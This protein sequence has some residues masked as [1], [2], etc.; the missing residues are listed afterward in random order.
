MLGHPALQIGMR[1]NWFGLA[2]ERSTALLGRISGS[3]VLSGI[4][5]SSTDHHCAPYSLT[6]E[7]VAVYRMHPLIPD[8]CDF[9]G[10]GRR[11]LLEQREF[12]ELAGPAHPRLMDSLD[13]GRPALL[14]RHA[15][16]PARSACTTIPT[17]P[18]ATPT[19]STAGDRPGGPRHPAR[20]GARVPR[21]NDFRELLRMPRP[22]S[23]DDLTDNTRPGRGDRRGLQRRRRDVDLQV[24]M[25][26]ETAAEGFGFCDTAFRIF[27][28]MASRRLKSDR[29]F[30]TDFTPGGLHAGRHAL[31]RR[32][33]HVVRAAAAL[34]RPRAGA[35]RRRER[36]RPVAAPRPAGARAVR[37]DRGRRPRPRLARPAAACRPPPPRTAT[38]HPG[39]RPR[40]HA[41][42]PRDPSAQRPVPLGVAAGAARRAPLPAVVRPVA[43]AAAVRRPAG[44]AERAASRRAPRARRRSASCPTRS[45]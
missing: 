40:R 24:G 33:R 34:P 16:T 41:D 36:V 25:Y 27:I 20:P 45:S 3:E 38:P 9:F 30:T 17:L 26:A 19:G 43:A 15:R 28:L 22:R 2:G 1:A 23:F 31:D 13:D 39:D 4:P 14:L 18:A 42:L 35:P 37:R 32:Q 44:A 10:L 11:A 7:F 12:P 29:F 8:D 5:G 21:Y 6:E